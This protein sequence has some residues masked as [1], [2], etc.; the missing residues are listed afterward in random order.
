MKR[1]ATFL[2]IFLLTQIALTTV[3]VVSNQAEATI[4][5]TCYPMP[6]KSGFL[7][8][9]TLGCTYNI[10]APLDGAWFAYSQTFQ[11]I[12][13]LPPG[14]GTCANVVFTPNPIQN[15]GSV[16]GIDEWNVYI[17]RNC[18]AGLV[19]AVHGISWEFFDDGEPIGSGSQSTAQGPVGNTCGGGFEP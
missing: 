6:V 8:K 15:G 9:P 3:D 13:I 2:C 5:T 10:N 11:C 14:L 4:Y 16:A 1:T 19:A 18:A 12:S 17:N 7:A